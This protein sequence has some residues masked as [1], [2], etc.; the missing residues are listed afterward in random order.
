MNHKRLVTIALL[1]I[2]T[3]F[4]AVAPC[5]AEPLA[6]K[7]PPPQWS[8]HCVAVAIETRENLGEVLD[9]AGVSYQRVTFDTLKDEAILSRFCVLFIGS[10]VPEDVSPTLIAPLFQW[11]RRGGAVYLSGE[12]R[13]LLSGLVG[14]QLVFDSGGAPRGDVEAQVVDAGLAMLVGPL[15][16]LH[17]EES[18]WPIISRA[19][20]QALVRARVRADSGTRDAIL[21]LQFDQADG[22]VM[23]S[24]FVNH[25]QLSDA[26]QALARAL[27]LRLINARRAG[28]LLRQYPALP[29][30]ALQLST[31]S[32]ANSTKTFKYAARAGQDFD[33]VMDDPG[34]QLALSVASPLTATAPLTSTGAHAPLNVV[35]VRAPAAGEWRLQVSSSQLSPPRQPYLLLVIP[36][37]GTNLF[38]S[39]PTPL[40]I[41]TD[42]LV[43]GT[44]LAL[45]VLITCL[46]GLGATLLGDR[47]L[48]TESP[49]PSSRTARAARALGA[50][51][52][53]A[54]QFY[55]TVRSPT[56][57]N[58]AGPLRRV[59][60]ALGVAAFF[61]LS[62]LV[63]AM[64][65]RPVSLTT[66]NGVG[67]FAGMF[68]A[69]GLINLVFAAGQKVAASV[70]GEESALRLRPLGLVGAFGLVM[71]CYVG[72]LMPGF[73]YALTLGLTLRGL[74]SPEERRRPAV[75]G[76]AGVL[77]VLLIGLI[78]W[79]LSVPT[80][81]VLRNTAYGTEGGLVFVNALQVLCLLIFFIALQIVF[82]EWLPIGHLA[83][84]YVFRW[85]WV[86]WGLVSVIISMLMVHTLVNPVANALGLTA[87]RNILALAAGLAFYTVAAM[88][89]WLAFH[90]RGVRPARS[91]ALAL[92]L[93][94]GLWL[95]ACACG[96]IT[97]GWRLFAAQLG[98]G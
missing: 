32:G 78:F 31:L 67:L 98:G 62:A 36:R 56:T 90:G 69:I 73:V 46:L 43:V 1:F 21:A 79:A 26:E 11:V 18:G 19:E 27:V 4:G 2:C 87:N 86:V 55:N 81:L 47:P 52:Q 29:G 83:G 71:L 53:R 57:W 65:A 76:V 60:V 23:Y 68:V 95:A 34:G 80:D 20:G 70:L 72:G 84:G 8:D 96:L 39:I 58:V 75:M 94:I 42:P 49:V 35:E 12:A 85:S 93:M 41:S 7:E 6:Q 74:L 66:L 14:A 37:V 54:T 25:G 48:T 64:L 10:G 9:D 88:G 13:T 91:A 59:A 63:A 51:G 5:T 15:V 30:A 61:A 3:L 92:A 33:V 50:A 82:F 17:Y 89:V 28:Q 97:A 24:T 40:R 16:T 38:N 45:A 44:N 77:A 22:A